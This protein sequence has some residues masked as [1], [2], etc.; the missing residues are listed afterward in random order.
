MTV[1]EAARAWGVSVNTIRRWIASGE[2]VAERVERPQGSQWRVYAP[3]DVPPGTSHEHAPATPRDVPGRADG[4]SSLAPPDVQRAEALAAYGA[5]LLTPVLATVERLEAQTRDQ[6]ETIGRLRAELE[7]AHRV[8][9][10]DY[11]CRGTPI[12]PA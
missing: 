3:R 8:L 7:A 11:G 5:T 10:R 4:V 2:L 9:V 6:A 12:V 1:R